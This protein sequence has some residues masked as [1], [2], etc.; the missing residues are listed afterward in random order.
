MQKK[1]LWLTESL[2]PDKHYV[3]FDNYFCSP[4][5]VTYLKNKR[6]WVDT[7]L[8]RKRSRNDPLLTIKELQREGR[9][10]SVEIQDPKNNTGV[11]NWYDKKTVFL[12]SSYL[13]ER[14]TDKSQRFER[15]KK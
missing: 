4:E 11:T 7:K 15:S 6:L 9:R 2:L 14:P 5:H 1:W 3:S 8:D 13:G 10:A 12:I